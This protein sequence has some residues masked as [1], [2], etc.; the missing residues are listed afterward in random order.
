MADIKL[1]KDFD[2]F[3]G[4][5]G[6]LAQCD[7]IGESYA[8]NGRLAVNTRKGSNV[9]HENLGNNLYNDRVKYSNDSVVQ[10][11]CEDAIYSSADEITNVYNMK[12]Y[13][14]KSTM[15]GD[16]YCDF[17]LKYSELDLEP[18]EDYEDE[19][20][21]MDIDDADEYDWSDEDEDEEEEGE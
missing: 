3:I 2:L 9:F 16:I 5:D 14:D 10:S 11:Y 19:I 12:I 1:N 4:I 6:D 17:E 18:D 21:E 7:D 8:Q 20:E 13:R 15:Y